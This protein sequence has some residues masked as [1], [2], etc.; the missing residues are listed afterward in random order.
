LQIF[1]QFNF[2]HHSTWNSVHYLCN[3]RDVAERRPGIPFR[4]R[5]PPLLRRG[6][7]GPNREQVLL[8][9]RRRN[10][11]PRQRLTDAPRRQ[12]SRRAHPP[13]EEPSAPNTAGE[14]GE[15]RPPAIPGLRH[16]GALQ[17]AHS[18]GRD[19][20]ESSEA[21]KRINRVEKGSNGEWWLLGW[22]NGRRRRR[23]GA[24]AGGGPKPAM[25]MRSGGCG[26]GVR[27]G[28]L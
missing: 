26:M 6:P 11:P 24:A 28:R 5:A 13:D 8:V 4:K 27:D 12:C 15:G 14:V 20:L 10:V 16:L 9:P 2:S 1:E 18:G 22:G 19:I 17:D 21:S 3:C 7:Q 23:G 25:A